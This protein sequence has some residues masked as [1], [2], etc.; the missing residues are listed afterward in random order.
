MSKKV[1]SN[2][3]DTLTELYDE[4][5]SYIHAAEWP[6]E[7]KR[8]RA[9]FRQ[10]LKL[11]SQIERTML[12]YF[13]DFAMNRALYLVDWTEYN[14]R[15]KASDVVVKLK[16]A[17]FVDEETI[18]INMLFDEVLDGVGLGAAAAEKTYRI[19]LGMTRDNELIMEQARSH[20]AELVKDL[21]K[22]TRDRISKSVESSIA[23]GETVNE[24][25]ERMMKVIDDPVRAR[26]IAQ[27]ETVQSYSD[28]V[29]TFGKE[30]GAVSK[31]W[32]LSG[33]PCPICIGI[34]EDGTV[35]INDSFNDG[36]DA[37]PAHPNC[38]CILLLN[39]ESDAK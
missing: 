26:M 30:S 7:Y 19:P 39:Y 21:N 28:G 8:D 22:T 35:G 16:D 23:L 27:T 9:N 17:K 2:N 34:A 4:L 1:V 38:R 29:L 10:L 31:T 20:A 13:R 32:E 37:P 3:I 15:I 36:S 6:D 24:A 14:S 12:G 5:G 25:A 18:L 11:E 33:D